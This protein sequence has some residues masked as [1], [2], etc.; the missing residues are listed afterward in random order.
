MIFGYK[1][2]LLNEYGLQEMR[3]I[4]ISTTPQVLRQLGEFLLAMATDLETVDS[5]N[6]HRHLPQALSKSLG[7]DIVIL[8]SSLGSQ[9]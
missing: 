2:R 7:C 4:S 9:K 3:E 5:P 1:K 8:P 6:W